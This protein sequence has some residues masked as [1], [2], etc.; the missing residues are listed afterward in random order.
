MV[1][2]HPM[3]DGLIQIKPRKCRKP[4][5]SMV[6]AV[7]GCR[8]CSEQ[9]SI[10]AIFKPTPADRRKEGSA[11]DLPIALGVL[12]ASKQIKQV[13]LGNFALLGEL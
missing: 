9:Q 3:S 11:F 7:A 4:V 10:C 1:M 6:M 13:R 8:S 2:A 5:I 12:V